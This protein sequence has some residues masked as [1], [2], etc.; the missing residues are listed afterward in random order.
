MAH[1]FPVGPPPPPPPPGSILPTAVAEAIA[2]RI[3]ARESNER[4][5][6]EEK[7]REC[8]GKGRSRWESLKK[9]E[10]GEKPLPPIDGL[11]APPKGFPPISEKTDRQSKILFHKDD[12]EIYLTAAIY[13]KANSAKLI[14]SESK[15]SKSDPE[16]PLSE[17]VARALNQLTA[18]KDKIAFSKIER[19]HVESTDGQRVVKRVL[20]NLDPKQL[21]GPKFDPESE[22]FFAL[23]GT[24][25]ASASFYL[26]KDHGKQ[27][28]ISG[29]EW[30]QPVRRGN[31]DG[32]IM[33]FKKI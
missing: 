31:C 29:I 1:G 9:V 10:P 19:F 24:S 27:L 33:K 30:I 11:V 16:F 3:A 12:E 26:I 28:G 18:D 5:I 13:Q 21:K 6:E 4:A 23:L 32:F 14:V 22:Q 7:Y 17:A 15:K 25:N 8:I 20:E 2:A